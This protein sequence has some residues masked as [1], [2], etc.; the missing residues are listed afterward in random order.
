MHLVRIP[1]G[2]TFYVDQFHS[3]SSHHPTHAQLITVGKHLADRHLTE[4]MA[5]QCFSQEFHLVKCASVVVSAL[6]KGSDG[7]CLMLLCSSPML[8]L[9]D[10]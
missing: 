5:G 9:V 6:F 4:V 1:L 7:L 2:N 8:S 3:T 10:C